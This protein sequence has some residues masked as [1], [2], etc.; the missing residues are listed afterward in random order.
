MTNGTNPTVLRRLL[1][2]ELLD[3]VA[4]D[5]KTVPQNEAYTKITQNTRIGLEQITETVAL[6]QNS[7]IQHEFR[8]TLVP[9]MVFTPE[10][11]RRISDWVGVG[12]FVLQIFRPTETVLD[13]VLREVTF[14][15]EELA[16]IQEA[17]RE[18]GIHIR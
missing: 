2:L 1:R 11:I 14:T 16:L 4:V 8:T 17:A 9:Q 6:L 5:I 12:H 10:E 15:E 3:F 7:N 18:L 13:P